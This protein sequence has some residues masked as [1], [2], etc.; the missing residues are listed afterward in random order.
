MLFTLKVLFGSLENY[1][2]MNVDV[3]PLKLKEYVESLS[4]TGFWYNNNNVK[5]DNEELIYTYIPSHYIQYI[6][7]MNCKTNNNEN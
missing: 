2:N 6:E 7:A 1:L 3:D 4:R 5:K